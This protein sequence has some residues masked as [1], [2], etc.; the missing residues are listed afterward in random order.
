MIT[1]CE[2]SLQTM[3]GFHH[4]RGGA[5]NKQTH[6]SNIMQVDRLLGNKTST[7]GEKSNQ[8]IC[9][10]GAE[11]KFKYIYHSNCTK[12]QCQGDPMSSTNLK[13]CN[14]NFFICDRNVSQIKGNLLRP[15]MVLLCWIALCFK[16]FLLFCPAP[17]DQ[18]TFCTFEKLLLHGWIIMDHILSATFLGPFFAC[19]FNPV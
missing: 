13:G 11:C 4:S 18:Y 16:V 1:K 12:V 3:L 6:F 8:T 7:F 19:L 5:K 17:V 10:G 14:V 2:G 9:W 15:F